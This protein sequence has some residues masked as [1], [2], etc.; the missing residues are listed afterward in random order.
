M[1]L[2]KDRY[3]LSLWIVFYFML[4]REDPVHFKA[5]QGCCCSS[6]NSSCAGLVRALFAQMKFPWEVHTDSEIHFCGFGPVGLGRPGT[7]G[8]SF[9]MCKETD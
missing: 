2:L 4:E 3:E 9:F 7:W 6:R 5:S 1:H 8:L